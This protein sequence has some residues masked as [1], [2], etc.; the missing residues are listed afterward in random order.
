M[1]LSTL[2]LLVSMAFTLDTFQLFQQSLGIDRVLGPD[3]LVFLV[4]RFRGWAANPSVP[5]CEDGWPRVCVAAAAFPY[6]PS[7]RS[8]VGPDLLI[9]P[10]IFCSSLMM[11]RQ[12]EQYMGR[13]GSSWMGI[14]QT[15]RNANRCVGKL[16]YPF[17][18]RWIGPRLWSSW[19]I[20]LA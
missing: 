20:F 9:L 11:G 16:A 18:C 5:R 6:C 19:P 3:V 2:F 1:R 14:S 15:L 17:S 10:F 7:C 8:G 12:S 4:D 13:V